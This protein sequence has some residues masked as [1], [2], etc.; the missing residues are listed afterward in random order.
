MESHRRLALEPN[1]FWELARSL[2]GHLYQV[3]MF[4]SFLDRFVG[5]FKHPYPLYVHATREVGPEV[6][7]WAEIECLLA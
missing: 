5:L 4:G 7:L 1:G 2:S 6:G 3:S